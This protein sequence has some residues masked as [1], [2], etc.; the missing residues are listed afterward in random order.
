MVFACSSSHSNMVC[1]IL[2]FTD[3]GANRGIV[4][5]YARISLL[6]LKDLTYNLGSFCSEQ[7]VK[8]LDAEL[9]LLRA[10][11]LVPSVFTFGFGSAPDANMLS[12]IAEMGNGLY[13]AIE[14]AEAIPAAFADC[15]GGLL[16]VCAEN[17]RVKIEVPLVISNTL[18]CLS[19]DS[20]VQILNG[21]TISKI[22][23]NHSIEEHS[24]L[25]SYSLLLGDIY[26]EE[27]LITWVRC[28]SENLTALTLQARDI[29]LGLTIPALDQ[30][31]SSLPILVRFHQPVSYPYNQFTLCHLLR[32]PL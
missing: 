28:C 20:S 22:F 16:S 23:G 1:S 4:Q 32:P 26:Y 31:A 24:P 11:S 9:G 13:Y 7:I 17:M 6:K 27:V 21:T 3:G 12:K 10:K 19:D 29:L 8:A 14:A 30:P 18:C 15:L 25:K 2:L 5:A